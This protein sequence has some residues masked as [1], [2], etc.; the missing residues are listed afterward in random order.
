LPTNVP[1]YKDSGS[2]G[3]SSGA[4]AGIAI[5]SA[6]VLAAVV[7][8][9]FLAWQRHKRR[10]ADFNSNLM[11][12][13]VNMSQHRP[14]S[15][16]GGG[17]GAHARPSEDAVN[18][19]S[20][21]ASG[22]PG[23]SDDRTHRPDNIPAGAALGAGIYGYE[24][25]E[26]QR[27]RPHQYYPATDHRYDSSYVAHPDQEAAYMQ[28]QQQYY[29]HGYQADHDWHNTAAGYYGAEHDYHDG[30]EGYYDD[31]HGHHVHQAGSG[32]GYDAGEVSGPGSSGLSANQISPPVEHATSNTRQYD[33]ITGGNAEYVGPESNAPLAMSTRQRVIPDP[34]TSPTIKVESTDIAA[35]RS[36]TG[37]SRTEVGSGGEEA[38]SKRFSQLSTSTAAS[39]RP[40][41]H[42][43]QLNPGPKRGPQALL[44]DKE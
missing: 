38:Y 29:P 6:V 4:I 25:E 34:F 24:A 11:F 15:H 39:S 12:N 14:S 19:N 13:P 40:Q 1:P 7:S 5:G 31:S 33:N 3:L 2:G 44:P 10:K 43:P 8:F 42:S 16:G 35:G 18:A 22:F 23:R 36:S 30:Y 9:L 28:Y 20:L 27:G 26:N 21:S 37:G 17:I 41:S 32:Y